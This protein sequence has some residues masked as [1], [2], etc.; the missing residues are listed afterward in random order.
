MRFNNIP[1]YWHCTKSK[2]L[3]LHYVATKFQ[4]V[5]T[6]Y[7]WIWHHTSIFSF[8]RRIITCYLTLWLIISGYY[9]PATSVIF[10]LLSS[11]RNVQNHRLGT[12]TC[13]RLLR[14]RECFENRSALNRWE[15]S[16]I[17]FERF[18]RKRSRLPTYCVFYD[19]SA[20]LQLCTGEQLSR[21]ISLHF[22]LS[23]SPCFSL[24]LSVCSNVLQFLLLSLLLDSDHCRHW[25]R[26]GFMDAVPFSRQEMP[27][28][29][30]LR[31]IATA[32]TLSRALAS[33]IGIIN[34]RRGCAWC[35]IV[36]NYR[37]GCLAS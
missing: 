24:S 17:K 31:R 35:C 15:T 9:L 36:V 22:Y 23:F 32:G 27:R 3:K 26:P 8:S 2:F 21:N 7:N 33:S 13:F 19:Q 20:L 34:Y 11:S 5:F 37:C 25:S 16:V 10:A 12:G 14:R 29:I 30:L 28:P 18:R 4:L 6:H 1:N